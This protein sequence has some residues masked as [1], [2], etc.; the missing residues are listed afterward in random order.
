MGILGRH[1]SICAIIVAAI[2]LLL[3]EYYVF[4]SLSTNRD[5]K[6]KVFRFHWIVLVETFMLFCFR[7]IWKNLVSANENLFSTQKLSVIWKLTLLVFFGCCQ[8]SYLS[9]YLLT[10]TDPHWFSVVCFV[11]F[12]TLLQFVF[13]FFLLGLVMR[14]VCKHRDQVACPKLRQLIA[15]VIS[16]SLVGKG[17]YTTS[18]LPEVRHVEVPVHNLPMSLD[19]FR[20]IQLSDIH[21]GPTVGREMLKRVVQLTNTLHGGTFKHL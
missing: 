3:G 20:I 10:G 4:T 15:L 8:F 2:S 1:K 11:C 16:L 14:L 6:F 21:L 9:T 5:L 13:W 12:G 17:L 18:Q 19:G 7:Y